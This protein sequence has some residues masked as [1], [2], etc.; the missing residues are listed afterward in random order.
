MKRE[1][2][3]PERAEIIRVEKEN[4]TI[5][6][7]RLKLAKG[8]GL[9]FMPGQFVQV[10]VLGVGEA[11]IS[12]CSS[13]FERDYFEISV[14]NVGNV[15]S[16]LFRLK[17]GDT[18]G[19]RGPY[20]NHY[21][22]EKFRWKDM[23]LVAGGVGFPPLNSL[24]EYLAR[25]RGHYGRI[26]LLYGARTPEDLIFRERIEKWKRRG[27]G[28]H[29]TVDRPDRRWKGDVGVVT[30]LFD[31][32]KIKGE[33]GIACGPPVMMKFVTQ[34]F[35]KIGIGDKDIY[36]SLE[37]MM[38]CGMGKCGHCNIGSKY[39]CLDGPVFTYDE[40][41]GVTEKVWR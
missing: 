16:A 39:V 41:K 4:P 9:K 14:R 30:T 37:R 36:L 40:L 8:K 17:E 1:N 22:V 11:P 2:Y 27:I 5:K 3:A 29:F 21:P 13:P 19:I 10:S 28:I 23:V 31:R 7:F 26:F 18:L 20:G 6:T 34:S 33:I 32:H 38:Q 24:V 35:Q 25:D 15:T 12:M